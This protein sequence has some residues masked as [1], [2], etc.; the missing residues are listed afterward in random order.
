M[1]G[2]IPA[3][4]QHAAVGLVVLLRLNATSSVQAAASASIAS[5]SYHTLHSSSSSPAIQSASSQAPQ[6]YASNDS[7]TFSSTSTASVSAHRKQAGREKARLRTLRQ[8]EKLLR[9]REKDGLSGSSSSNH[10]DQRRRPRD[11]VE[12]DVEANIREYMARTGPRGE[13][14]T[15]AQQE[16]LLKQE[17]KGLGHQLEK[18]EKKAK[19]D[20]AAQDLPELDDHT[21]EELYQALMLPPPP[22]AEEVRLARLEGGRREKSL[23]EV[24]GR[25]RQRVGSLGGA[26]ARLPPTKAEE[27]WMRTSM[28]LKQKL[29]VAREKGKMLLPPSSSSVQRVEQLP[30][31]EA[32]ELEQVVTSEVGE[33]DMVAL[34]YAERQEIRLQQLFARLALVHSASDPAEPSTAAESNASS[35]QDIKSN[36]AHRIAKI[37]HEHDYELQSVDRQATQAATEEDAQPLPPFPEVRLD[38]RAPALEAVDAVQAAPSTG[39]A[40]AEVRGN[41]ITRAESMISDLSS[42]ESRSFM[43]DS[44]EK[45]VRSASPTPTSAASLPLGVATTEEWTAL[46]IASAKANDT[47]TLSRTMSLMRASGYHPAPL[48]LYNDVMDVFATQGQSSL[49][50]E[51]LAQ[52]SQLGLEPDNHTYHSLTKAYANTAQ[53]LPAIELLNSLE[54]SGRPASMATYTLMIDRLLDPVPSSA[55]GGLEEERPEL[56]ALAWNVFYHMRLHAHAVPDA[57]LYALMIRACA[58]GVPQPHDIDDPTQPYSSLD[59]TASTSPSMHKLKISDA[60][61]A[62]DLF[63]EMTTRYS[64]RPNAEVYNALILACSRRKEFY[65]EAFRLLREMVELEQERVG[66]DQGLRFAPDRYTFNALLQ[67]CA[68]SRDLPRARWVLAEMIRTTM[69]LFED[70]ARE[71]LRREEVMELW[72]KRPNEESMC[73]V[74]HSYASYVPPLKRALLQKQGDAAGGPG[75]SPVTTA[76]TDADPTTDTASSTPA[77]VSQS[78]TDVT[79]THTAEDEG[80]TPEEAAHIFSALVPQTAADLVSESRSLFAR[81]LADQPT[82][83]VEGP[84]GAVTPGVRLVNA[85]LTVLAAHLPAHQ[86]AAVLHSTLS[87]AAKGIGEEGAEVGSLEHALFARLGLEPNEHSYRIVLESLS[88]ADASIDRGVVHEVWDRFA[89]FMSYPGH[90]IVQT[91]TSALVSADSLRVLYPVDAAQ[92]TKCWSAYIHYHAKNSAS[93]GSGLDSAMSLLRHFVTLYPPPISPASGASGGRN[94]KRSQKRAQQA[95]RAQVP[96]LDLSPLPLPTKSLQSLLTL[97]SPRSAEARTSHSH[98]TTER[99]MQPE[100]RPTSGYPTLQFLD[101]QLLHH[102]LVRYARTKDLAYLSWCLHRYA[103]ARRHT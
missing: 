29:I 76:G 75:A 22:T 80:T 6:R 12:E 45:L 31:Q 25:G 83:N 91:E 26:F 82:A 23:E 81:V 20:E 3:R 68:R 52:M 63:R 74:F 66:L 21:L 55:S 48:S 95:S 67:G 65:L 11:P 16:R 15:R 57:P 35:L 37:L 86:R 96:H 64:V 18:L 2:R 79:P 14:L 73:H 62:L 101:V 42:K 36:L 7:R 90:A 89:R 8:E 30:V 85:Y 44:I 4:S 38:A 70:G 28:D 84:L 40:D 59:P 100:G 51:W 39:V 93:D 103:A 58:R 60:E 78:P 71:G 10:Q 56:Q 53:F 54:T 27:R 98:T 72:A 102:R 49:C 34:P 97:Q 1:V 99:A 47:A 5:T 32:S 88:D 43:L 50:Q 61:R 77:V 19:A 69:G 33:V 41:L 92:V 24:V 87:P 94:H 13:R 17:L 9:R 46:A